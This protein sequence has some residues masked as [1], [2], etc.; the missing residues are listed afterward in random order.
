MGLADLQSYLKNEL[1]AQIDRVPAF[2]R[3]EVEAAA[4]VRCRFDIEDIPD[5]DKYTI[6]GT[7]L[8]LLK[9]IF[10]NLMDNFSLSMGTDEPDCI[11]P[12]NFQVTA[13]ERPCPSIHFRQIQRR[14]FNDRHRQILGFRPLTNGEKD[15]LHHGLFVSSAM[16]RFLGGYAWI[17]NR[18][19]ENYGV[20]S[21]VEII[22]PL[23][24]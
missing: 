21:I 16:A 11:G 12:D 4:M 13:T 17:G 20:L 15:R 22:V 6:S 9:R 24:D 8:V 2:V 14:P 7:R 5:F 18:K 1:Q 19:A 23:K 10:R 3:R